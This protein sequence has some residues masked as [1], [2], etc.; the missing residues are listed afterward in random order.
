MAHMK[1]V[2][3]GIDLRALP[4]KPRK[5]ITSLVATTAAAVGTALLDG[6]LTVP[7]LLASVGLGLLAGAAVWRVPNPVDVDKLGLPAVG[8]VQVVTTLPERPP[9][10]PELPEDG[11]N[12]S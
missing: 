7:E 1:P 3:V 9:I 5:A 10:A 4:T 6:Q 8:P 11:P 2:R 12:V